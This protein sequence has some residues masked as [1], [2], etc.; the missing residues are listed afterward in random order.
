MEVLRTKRAFVLVVLAVGFSCAMT[1]L[2]WPH[3]HP[4]AGWA[5]QNV[6]TVILF[7]E[8]QL[9]AAILI[10]PAFT[11]GAISGERERGTY[12]LLHAT[13]LSPR[14]IVF[15]KA[16]AS[17]GFVLILLAA[18]A[19]MA[20]SLYLLGGVSFSTMLE[21]YA[22]TFA[23]VILSGWI[24]LSA[25]MRSERTSGAVVRGM[26]WI[27]FWN[28]LVFVIA[29]LIAG[30]TTGGGRPPGWLSYLFTLSPHAAIFWSVAQPTLG[31]APLFVLEPWVGSV[32]YSMLLSALILAFL[33]LRARVPDAPESAGDGAGRLRGCLRRL[34]RRSFLTRLVLLLGDEGAP[35][36]RNPVFLKEIRS[37][38]FGRTVYRSCIFWGCLAVFISFAANMRRWEEAVL[39][40][41][42]AALVFASLLA[43]ATAASAFTREIE[44]GNIDFLRGTL[45][46]F[47]AILRGKLLASLYSVS[48]IALAAL[49]CCF[50]SIFAVPVTCAH[51]LSVLLVAMLT[52]V[53]IALFA[54]AIRRRT[55]TALVGAYALLLLWLVVWPAFLA[56]N[57]IDS[58]EYVLIATSP[59]GALFALEGPPN[60]LPAEHITALVIFHVAHVGAS[61][62]LFI[63][64]GTY[65]ALTRDRDR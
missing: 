15:S 4:S 59:F 17:I 18:A 19:P 53:A 23:S 10:I 7:L 49:V 30:L 14:A 54:S 42:A 43:P 60:P 41:F 21:C 45:L 44:Q 36:L 29:F 61:L 55:L 8:T 62:V 38:F 1:L 47:P 40:V 56:L 31:A 22:V 34:K 63:L 11:A 39:A 64:A 57:N 16:L 32:A 12:E 58:I 9:T 5:Q 26:G 25:S 52:T 13:L 48:G 65:L 24:C 20:C 2:A 50:P 46:G 35:G 3:G 28:G 37:E 51:A 27:I 6:F 33:L